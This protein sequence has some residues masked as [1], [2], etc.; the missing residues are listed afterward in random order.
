MSHKAGI[1]LCIIFAGIA[2]LVLAM[3]IDLVRHPDH[4]RM[5][6]RDKEDYVVTEAGIIVKLREREEK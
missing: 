2:V 5:I 1:D 6:E 3:L 4:G